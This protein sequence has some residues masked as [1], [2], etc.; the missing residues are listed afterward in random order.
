[1]CG[2]QAARFKCDVNVTFV[3]K[4]LILFR[5]SKRIFKHLLNVLTRKEAEINPKKKCSYEI[6]EP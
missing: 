1:M 6:F 5:R 3:H 4:G 2:L